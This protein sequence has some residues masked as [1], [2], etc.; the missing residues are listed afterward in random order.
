VRFLL[1][2]LTVAAL[3]FQEGAGPSPF[4][5]G[6]HP[7]QVLG[8]ARPFRVL[9]PAG[10]ANST[11]RYPV[12]YWLTAYEQSSPAREAA[13][14]QYVAAHD[15]IVVQ[16]G[17]VET[18]GEYPLY[19]PE[20]VD[21]IDRTFRTAADRDR[22][23]VTGFA[24]GG[25]AA[26]LTAARYPDLVSSAS[27]FLGPTEGAAG[28]HNFEVDLNL[29]D[30]YSNLDAVRTRLIVGPRNPLEFYHRRLNATWLY[31]RTSH[32][33]DRLDSE[34]PAAGIVGALDFHMQSF[35]TPM[36]RPATFN[37]T[38]MYPSFNVWG[39]QVSSN[40]RQ[41][42]YTVLEN[43]GP[44]GFRSAVRQWLPSGAAIPEVKLSVTSPALAPPGGLRTV[45]YLRLKDGKV[46]RSAQKADAKG[47]FTFD[48]DGD[49]WEVGIGALPIVTVSGYALAEEPWASAGK[50]VKLDVRFCNKGAARFA[51][52]DV[53]FES[54]NAD[55][56]LTPATARLFGLAPGETAS[57]PVTV[58][59]TDAARTVVRIFAVL[60][61]LRLPLD[62]S[63]HPPA[64][65]APVFQIADG[66][67]AE[68]WQHAVEHEE[69][70]FG[71]GNGDGHAAGGETF[72]ILIPDGEYLRAAELFSADPCVDERMRGADSWDKYDRSGAS[73]RYSLDSLRA[74]CAPGKIIRMLARVL[75]PAHRYRYYSIEF[76]VWYKQ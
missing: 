33:T 72:A 52:G 60:G 62:V 57:L 22:R 32:E 28:P 47:R 2:L 23:G 9:L 14:A 74:D 21:H 63:L 12:L 29:D 25:F 51:S 36:P 66:L 10:Y 18:T 39:W 6:S 17:P 54:P 27:N 31:M 34:D 35:A 49:A 75:L 58:T 59:V 15:L 38:D 48:L 20:L 71:S 76:P 37:Y 4:I 5:A 73:A 67:S 45:T 7:S 56:T 68:V 44:Q 64:E 8:G 42:G 11:K 30:L 1:G 24:V 3:A 53:R 40:R 69:Q 50:P 46:R 16:I 41:P 55:V 19:F 61:N 13:F 43:A 65:P 26:W 70:A